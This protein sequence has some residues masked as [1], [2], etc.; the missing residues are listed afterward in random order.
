[1]LGAHADVTVRAGD[2]TLDPAALLACGDPPRLLDDERRYRRDHALRAR[3]YHERAE[4]PLQPILT[5]CPSPTDHT[6]VSRRARRRAPESGAHRSRGPVLG[7]A[8]GRLGAPRSSG[9]GDSRGGWEDRADSN[10][11]RSPTITQRP[12]MSRPSTKLSELDPIDGSDAINV[13]IETSRGARTKLAYDDRREAFVV[14]KVLPQGMSFP[15]DFG[16]IPSTLGED[17]DP[18]DVLVL[19]DESVPV[20]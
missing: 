1:D 2:A 11:R 3:V 18:L 6:G 4:L 12:A 13:V 8:Q 7:D 19:R 5:H 17:G 14:K 16:F 10:T 20:G 9:V 15:F